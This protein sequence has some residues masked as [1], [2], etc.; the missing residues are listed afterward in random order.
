MTGMKSKSSSDLAI[1]KIK[2]I[3]KCFLTKKVKSPDILNDEFYQTFKE[4][5]IN[6]AR[7]ISE[8]R[9]GSLTFQS[10]IFNFQEFI[11][12]ATYKT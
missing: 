11:W 3:T 5:N 2:C 1:K 7:I 6:F 8:T 10:F 9:G 4:K 12:V